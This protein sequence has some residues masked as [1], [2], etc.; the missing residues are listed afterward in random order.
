MTDF[1]ENISSKFGLI[2]SY[3]IH[4]KYLFVLRAQRKNMAKFFNLSPMKWPR[5]PRVS[6]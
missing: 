5:V 6:V 4:L 3:A 1:C 2:E